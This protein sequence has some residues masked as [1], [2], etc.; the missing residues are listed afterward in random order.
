MI[1][2]LK[3]DWQQWKD[4]WLSHWR[5][6]KSFFYKL[7]HLHHHGVNPDRL[8]EVMYQV[9]DNPIS[10]VDCQKQELIGSFKD[11]FKKM[12]IGTQIPTARLGQHGHSDDINADQEHKIN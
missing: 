11:D 2:G 8:S 3:F 4:F 5:K 1:I 12:Y 6:V 7:S 10:F 9:I